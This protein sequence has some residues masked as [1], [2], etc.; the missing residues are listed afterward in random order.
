MTACI[1]Q[2]RDSMQRRSI[3]HHWRTIELGGAEVLH[4]KFPDMFT[5]HGKGR[6]WHR[7]K[8]GKAATLFM[9]TKLRNNS[10]SELLY[11]R[12][13]TPKVPTGPFAV[14]VSG[15][16]WFHVQKPIAAMV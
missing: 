14:F 7:K 6:A 4:A 16:S 15:A 13:K 1:Y 9:P 12:Q 5:W 8:D 3:R 10:Q 11:G 2:M